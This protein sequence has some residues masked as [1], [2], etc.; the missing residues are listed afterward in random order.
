MEET[1]QE[2]ASIGEEKM[3]LFNEMSTLSIND[4]KNDTIQALRLQKM[5]TARDKTLAHLQTIQQNLQS[6]ILKLEYFLFAD[7]IKKQQSHNQNN[8]NGDQVG[9][10]LKLKTKKICHKTNTNTSNYILCNTEN[11]T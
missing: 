7:G 8:I 2:I 6:D 4:N 1:R 9:K 11:K 5:I 3:L 10:K